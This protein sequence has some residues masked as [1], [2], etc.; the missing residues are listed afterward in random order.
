M[1]LSNQTKALAARLEYELRLALGIAIVRSG[2]YDQDDETGTLDVIQTVACEACPV[3][4]TRKCGCSGIPF[5]SDEIWAVTDL[6]DFLANIDVMEKA[7]L[8]AHATINELVGRIQ[9]LEQEQTHG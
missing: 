5:L 9:Q 2:Y 8:E 6:T 7:L 4:Q 1:A 3:P